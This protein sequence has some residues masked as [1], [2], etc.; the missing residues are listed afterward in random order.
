M[1]ASNYDIKI[2][3]PAYIA[4][5]S[6]E[7]APV[8][9]GATATNP[10]AT[11]GWLYDPANSA[12]LPNL[13]ISAYPSRGPDNVNK[14]SA[15]RMLTAKAVREYSGINS[16]GGPQVSGRSDQSDFVFEQNTCLTSPY[17]YQHCCNCTQLEWVHFAV[18][19][20]NVDLFLHIRLQDVSITS[21]KMRGVRFFY[22]KVRTNAPPVAPAPSGGTAAPHIPPMLGGNL[23]IKEQ[24][25]DVHGVGHV[26][27][28]TLLYTN[29]AF[30][31]G[32][33][34]NLERGWSTGSDLEWPPRP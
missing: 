1:P 20:D 2:G 8:A 34:V 29:I 5:K 31:Y 17:L 23:I 32:G 6:K 26:D 15:V 10:P 30:K 7:L 24:E 27:R 33:G 3:G 9:A 12:N 18:V 13:P 22:D 16:S 28:V 11:V 4:M 19:Q 25:N 14:Y 21:Y